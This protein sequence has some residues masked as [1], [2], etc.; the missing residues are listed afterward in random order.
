MYNVQK[1][2]FNSFNAAFECSSKF[3]IDKFFN[4]SNAALPVLSLQLQKKFNE[5]LKI[6]C[7]T[8]KTNKFI[9]KFNAEIKKK[10]EMKK[11]FFFF[12]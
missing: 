9:V 12:F 3:C 6:E 4:V 8:R 5:Y 7:E 2:I 10:N 1:L 11:I